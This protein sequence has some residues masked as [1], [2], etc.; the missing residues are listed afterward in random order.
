MLRVSV[1]HVFGT[2][3]VLYTCPHVSCL[4]RRIH[5]TGRGLCIS[6]DLARAL[7]NSLMKKD[8][9]IHVELG[10]DV[11]YTMKG[12]G[13]ILFQL[14]SGGSLEAQDVLYVPQ[15][16]SNLLPVSVIEKRSFVV[17]FKKGKVL[18]HPEG[19]NLDTTMSIGVREGKLYKL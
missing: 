2:C 18:I 7:F 11:K 3:P 1:G 8:S 19:A 12:E 4:T 5:D 13:T 10:D 15:L 6:C 16:K 14:E 9:R 17:M